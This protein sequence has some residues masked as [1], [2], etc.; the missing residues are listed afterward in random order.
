MY[1]I[2]AQ[3]LFSKKTATVFVIFT[4]FGLL[5]TGYITWQWLF[6]KSV[7]VKGQKLVLYIKSNDSFNDVFNKL[8]QKKILQ[9]PWGFKQIASWLNLPQKLHAGRYVIDKPISNTE[10]INMLLK[11]RQQPF[12]I[13]FNYA[14]R[15]EEIAGFFGNK[16]ES[17][18]LSIINLLN[19]T[20]LI[21]SLGFNTNTI[22][23]LFVPNTYNFYWNTS[24]VELLN[25]MYKE[26]HTFWNADRQYKAK[27]AGLSVNDVITLASIVQKETNKID[28]MPV[29]AGVYINRLNKGIPLQADPT[30]LYFIADKNI[31]R[32]TSVYY[33][34]PSAYNTYLNKGL[35][36]GPICTPSAVVIDAVLNFTKHNY[37]YF[38]ARDDFSGYHAFAKNLNQHNVN[39]RKYQKALNKAGIY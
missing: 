39:A 32:V 7:N 1:K 2:T 26:Y 37:Y 30:I 28:E 3:K 11:G 9:N 14:A 8:N 36:P 15:K 12:N 6:K 17:D 31:K 20:A 34:K 27:Q 35:P 18:S 22:I 24:S 23:G 10:L 13:V 19:D 25:R 38:C 33:N 21:H 5:I 29:V 16:L 4:L